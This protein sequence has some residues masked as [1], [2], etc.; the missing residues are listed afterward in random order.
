MID[1]VMRADLLAGRDQGY[2][3]SVNSSLQCYDSG[4]SR[5]WGQFGDYYACTWKCSGKFL[6]L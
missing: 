5:R 4:V 1:C 6:F 3:V 2:V